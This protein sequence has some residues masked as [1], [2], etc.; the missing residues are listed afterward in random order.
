[1][2]WRFARAEPKLK[3]VAAFYGPNPPVEA[4]PGI[5][6]AVLGVYGAND[7]R[8][9]D[10]KGTLEDALKKVGKSFEM[11]VFEGADHAFFNDT[12]AR[13]SP[14]AAKEAWALTLDFF[15][16]HLN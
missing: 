9:T 4:V 13:Y 14:A 15:A 1:M 12:G 11:K 2:A 6:A 3:A 5:Q 8:I 10:A 16:R 7:K